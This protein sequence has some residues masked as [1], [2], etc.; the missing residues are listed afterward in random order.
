MK[1][2]GNGLSIALSKVPR[3][4]RLK[5]NQDCEFAGTILWVLFSLCNLCVNFQ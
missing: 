1:V 5:L 4:G 2:E 3:D